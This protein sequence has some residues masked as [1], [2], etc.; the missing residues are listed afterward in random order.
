VCTNELEV[1]L[2]P[3][4]ASF[5]GEGE[6]T[7]NQSTGLTI[8]IPNLFPV[9]MMHLLWKYPHPWVLLPHVKP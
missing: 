2:G 5:V 6:K 8:K 7:T 3:K 4:V 1:L 9:V